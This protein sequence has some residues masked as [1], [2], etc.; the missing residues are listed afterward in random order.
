MDRVVEEV[1]KITEAINSTSYMQGK[2]I[3][4]ITF[5]NQKISSDLIQEKHKIIIAS[6]HSLKMKL[7]LGGKLKANFPVFQSKHI[8][9]PSAD[10]IPSFAYFFQLLLMAENPRIYNVNKRNGQSHITRLYLKKQ[11]KL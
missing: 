6:H 5:R 4:T 2:K 1:N 9:T 3:D 11:I 8:D 10:I 7:T